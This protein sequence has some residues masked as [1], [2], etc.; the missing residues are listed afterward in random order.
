MPT[1]STPGLMLYTSICL[2]QNSLL[3]NRAGAL[4]LSPTAQLAA[5]ANV[6]QY[7]IRLFEYNPSLGRS[8][9]KIYEW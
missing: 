1:L 7:T 3:A 9:H 8:N 4:D 6:Y 5:I 2:A